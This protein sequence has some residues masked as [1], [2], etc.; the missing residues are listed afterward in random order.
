[1][2]VANVLMLLSSHL[3]LRMACEHGKMNTRSDAHGRD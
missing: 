3:I 2:L 1:M